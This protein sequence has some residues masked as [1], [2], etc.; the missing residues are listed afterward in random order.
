MPDRIIITG[1]SGFV[2]RQ[3]V[4]IL[5]GQGFELLLVGR[6]IKKLEKLFPGAQSCDYASLVAHGKGFDVL[7]HLAAQ[8]NHPGVDDST[9]RI[10]NVELLLSLA[11]TAEQIGIRRFIN[12]GS[13]H[14][15]SGNRDDAYGASKA[16]GDRLLR[17]LNKVPVSVIV[18]PA[19]YG[20]TFQG[21]L[22]VIERF[23]G[24]LHPT[25]IKLLSLLKPVVSVQRLATVIIEEARRNGSETRSQIVADDQR[26]NLIY[27]F[28]SRA[29]DLTVAIG[30]LLLLGGVMAVVA[31]LIRIK[32]TGPAIFA[33]ER[34]G[35]DGR[36]FTCY[37]FRT[38]AVGTPQR[39]THE[40]GEVMVTD[41]GRFLRRTKLDELPQLFNLLRNEM[42][43]VGP[44]PCLPVQRELVERRRAAS[45]LSIKPGI[46][47]LAQI[48]DIDMSDPER[49]VAVESQYL[50][51]RT[52]MFDIKIILATVTGKGQGDRTAAATQQDANG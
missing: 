25:L 27:R 11:Q 4:P 36:L 2:G 47:G 28:L 6:D 3:I 18:A 5:R 12:L 35:R 13:T 14:S 24:F 8:N 19:I 1:A 20:K 23:P 41:I 34:V 10:A 52:L 9:F 40:V 32:S 46:T 26:Q 45:V 51:L 44:R 49:L 29:M 7:L 48:Q 22:K 43:L 37:K 39:A 17:G 38:M 15:L 50:A 30:L 42:S 33:Q 31:L 21:N 16:E